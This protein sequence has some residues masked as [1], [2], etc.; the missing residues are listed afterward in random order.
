M[1][2]RAPS[3]AQLISMIVFAFSCFALILFLWVS[4]GGPVP[5]KP[6]GYR[7]NVTFSEAVQLATEADV[8][9]S[10][11]PVGKVK[12]VQPQQGRTEATLEIQPRYAPLPDDIKAILRSKTLLGET[13]VELSP[14]TKG[15]RT[16]PE[17]G[18]ISAAQVSNQ[19]QLD[20]VIRTFDPVTRRAFGDWLIG[21]S[22]A[23]RGHGDQ[24]N[25][26]FGVLPMF[27]SD[28]N[29]LMDV[30]HRQ[31]KALSHVFANTA[32]I[33][34]AIDSRPG[35]L[36]QLIQT[37]NRLLRVTSNRSQQLTDTFKNFPEFLRQIRQTTQ[38][39]Q[40]F[41]DGTQKLIS[42]TGEFADA[43]SPIMKKSVR[44]TND[45]RL[46]INNLEP[47]LDKADAGLP[48]TN[49]FLDLAKPTLAQLD[50]FLSNLN[51]VLQFVGEYQRELTAFAANDAAASQGQLSNDS[52]FVGRTKWGH[53]LRAFVQLTPDN[54]AYFPKKTVKT[55]SNAYPVPGWYDRLA[56]GLQVFDSGA[57]GTIPVP[58]LDP[59]ATVYPGATARVNLQSLLPYINQIVYAGEYTPNPTAP[60]GSPQPA[61][62]VTENVGQSPN[63]AANLPAPNCDQ[64]PTQSFQGQSLQF[65]HVNESSNANP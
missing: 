3:P 36:T 20:E 46:L 42:N 52:P 58:S 21:Q 24:L 15:G 12:K 32:D 23:V 53:Y 47:M 2:K 4:F 11:V 60:V 44:V 51:P 7:V 63:N 34:E 30:L 18:S 17:N 35:E 31:D 19:V 48:A 65:P 1:I 62:A 28:T 16:I 22:D 56:S 33:F 57:C 59:D 39:F 6:Q 8:R 13:Y 26:A 38:Q 40:E 54:L 45:A 61:P 50:P 64:Q 9:I 43:S 5:L 10:G 37:S 27:F 55:R 49:Q 25:Q 14:G 41:S 29:S